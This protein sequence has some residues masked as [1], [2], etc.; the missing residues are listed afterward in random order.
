MFLKSFSTKR[1]LHLILAIFYTLSFA[2]SQLALRNLS[3]PPTQLDQYVVVPTDPRKVAETEAAIKVTISG[4][5]QTIKSVHSRS[6]AEYGGVQL[7]SF[8]ASDAEIALLRIKIVG[9][10]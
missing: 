5:V 6:R 2:A 4:L 8:D 10:V 3:A 1:C 7:W 9:D